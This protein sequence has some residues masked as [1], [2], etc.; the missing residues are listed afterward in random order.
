[1]LASEPD[2]MNVEETFTD[3][4]TSVDEVSYLVTFSW[5]NWLHIC[6]IYIHV[7][8]H[9]YLFNFIYLFVYRCCFALHKFTYAYCVLSP[10]SPASEE[11]TE[12]QAIAEHGGPLHLPSTHV[13]TWTSW[14]RIVQYML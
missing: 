13:V 2:G 14:R 9:I 4:E 12:E 10:L 7:Y 8:T 5:H 3:T 11:K 6:I 1:M